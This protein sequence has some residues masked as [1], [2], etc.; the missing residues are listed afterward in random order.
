MS[1]D[2]R[3][4]F[5]ERGLCTRPLDHGSEALVHSAGARGGGW[6]YI[7]PSFDLKRTFILHS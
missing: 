3:A 6:Y 4:M 1:W 7:G 5:A 2:S